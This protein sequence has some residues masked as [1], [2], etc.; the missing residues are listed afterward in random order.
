MVK[1]RK[2]ISFDN[3]AYPTPHWR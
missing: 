2:M 1:T 3:P